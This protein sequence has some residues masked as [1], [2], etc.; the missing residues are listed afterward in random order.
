M[1]PAPTPTSAWYASGLRW[2]ASGF[3]RLADAIDRDPPAP[4]EPD[5]YCPA[6]EFLRRGNT[7]AARLAT[8]D[9]P[10]TGDLVT[11]AR[12]RAQRGF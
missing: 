1:H 9:L 4:P 5:D 8:G 2:I 6:R 10:A 7:G 12:L 11:E 3:T